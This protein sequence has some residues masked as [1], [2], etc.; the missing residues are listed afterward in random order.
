MY[1]S[2]KAIE[3]PLA[4]LALHEQRDKWLTYWSI[5]GALSLAERWELFASRDSRLRVLKILNEVEDSLAGYLVTV[6]GINRLG[7]TVSVPEP[8]A[9]VAEAIASD[10]IID[11]EAVGERLHAFDAAGAR[12][13]GRALRGA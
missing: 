8:I 7:L 11:G 13:P 1:E 9:A 2:F 4:P 5:H 3:A 10:F 6:T 12:V